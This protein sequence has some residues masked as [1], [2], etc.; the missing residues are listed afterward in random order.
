MAQEP[1]NNASDTVRNSTQT[2]QGEDKLSPTTLILNYLRSQGVNP[3]NENIRRVLTDA[4]GNPDLIPGLRV[5]AAE[6]SSPATRQQASGPPQ[7]G[8]PTQAMPVPPTPP[9][10]G[11][12]AVRSPGSLMSAQVP[13]GAPPTMPSMAAPQGGGS[14]LG[15]MILLGIPPA[16]AGG[17]LM[18]GMNGL[19]QQGGRPQLPVTMDAPQPGAPPPN[20]S[21]PP[22]NARGQQVPVDANNWPVGTDDWVGQMVQKAAEPT[23]ALPRDPN[24]A[25]DVLERSMYRG[26]GQQEQQQK[27]WSRQP[28]NRVRAPRVPR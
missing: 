25:G 6:D 14:D 18:Y 17:A 20:I 23:Q 27:H 9:I 24:Y 2:D 1:K 10:G 5:G 11:E 16:L 7:R 3:S 19:A 26:I 15:S 12:S 13:G 8:A 28:G 22:V 4:A 21:D